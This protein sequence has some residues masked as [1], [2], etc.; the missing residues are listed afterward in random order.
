[1]ARMTTEKGQGWCFTFI[2]LLSVLA[3]PLLWVEEIRGPMWRETRRINNG[4]LYV[5][6]NSGG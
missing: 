1:M 3:V 4:E 6:L 5:E 2:W